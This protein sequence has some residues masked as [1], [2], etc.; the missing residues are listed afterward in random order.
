MYQTVLFGTDVFLRLSV[1][2]LWKHKFVQQQVELQI[3]SNE[4]LANQT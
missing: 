2:R 3:H 4:I 1:G